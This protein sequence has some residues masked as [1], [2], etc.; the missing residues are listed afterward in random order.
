MTWIVRFD[1]P[2]SEDISFPLYPGAT[3]GSS[4]GVQLGARPGLA[5]NCVVETYHGPQDAGLARPVRVDELGGLR[6]EH[7]G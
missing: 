1:A 4:V 7:P 6:S 2:A 5:D 3:I